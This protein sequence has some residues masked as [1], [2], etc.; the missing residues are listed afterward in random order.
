MLCYKDT[1]EKAVNELTDLRWRAMETDMKPA[2]WAQKIIEY[3]QTGET[4]ETWLYY[5]KLYASR[6]SGP[7]RPWDPEHPWD[8]EKPWDAFLFRAL[9]WCHLINRAA[10]V[11]DLL[12]DFGEECIDEAFALKHKLCQEGIE[13]VKE[14]LKNAG[15][16]ETSITI[17]DLLTYCETDLDNFELSE[18]Y[19]A[20][21]A[22]R[23]E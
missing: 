1:V 4:D 9:R 12:T 2:E 16:F 10:T 11:R 15:Y 20:L 8:H 18:I 6:P 22:E 7:D 3:L 14:C 23:D 13:Y 21:C 17:I 5:H 19:M